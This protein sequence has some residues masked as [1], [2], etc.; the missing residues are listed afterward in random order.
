MLLRPKWHTLPNAAAQRV[1]F[2]P[3]PL[4]SVP[5]A[6]GGR[7]LV[8]LGVLLIAVALAAGAL[9]ANAQTADVAAEHVAARSQI[10][11]LG[12]APSTA[13]AR[14]MTAL[15]IDLVKDFEGWSAEAYDDPAG[16]CTI[17]YGHLIA[18]RVCAEIELGEFAGA[19]TKEEGQRIL[20]SDTLTARRA[21]ESLVEQELTEDQFSAVA[22]FVFNVGR[23]RF[24][25]ST[26]RALLNDGDFEGAAGQFGRWIVAGGNVLQGLVS[27]RQCESA[28]FA[29]RLTYD[30]FGRF[31]RSSCA[32]LGIAPEAGPLVD[33]DIGE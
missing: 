9:P 11:Q 17:G 25:D 8:R 19:I 27:R 21:V 3:G 15:S 14:E 10:E 20:I 13:A 33:I 28:L 24:R 29:G 26:L 16:Y 2:C 12:S 22:S 32:S 6:S 1:L 4:C 7:G 5:A 30:E 31:D 23:R 18:R